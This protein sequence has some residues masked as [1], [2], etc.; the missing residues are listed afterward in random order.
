MRECSVCPWAGRQSP[1]GRSQP[2]PDKG[3]VALPRG[4]GEGTADP[5]GFKVLKGISATMGRRFWPGAFT[6]FAG[7]L[8]QQ[9]ELTL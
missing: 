4:C 5:E 1:Q 7:G 3:L 6:A 9:A 2:T 8:S